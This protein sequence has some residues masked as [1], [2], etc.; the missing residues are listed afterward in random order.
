M[1]VYRRDDLWLERIVFQ[2][3]WTWH[4]V[5]RQRDLTVHVDVYTPT[6]T[7][8][9]ELIRISITASC[10]TDHTDPYGRVRDHAVFFTF[11]PIRPLGLTTDDLD[12][13]LRLL[14]P[15]CHRQTEYAMNLAARTSHLTSICTPQSVLAGIDLRIQA[16]FGTRWSRYDMRSEERARHLWQGTTPPDSQP[17]AGA[18]SSQDPPAQI[19]ASTGAVQPC[20][21]PRG[22]VCI[23]VFIRAHNGVMLQELDVPSFEI[24]SDSLDI[25]PFRSWRIDLNNGLFE[26]AGEPV[27]IILATHPNGWQPNIAHISDVILERMENGAEV[28]DKEVY[29]DYHSL[30]HERLNQFEH[31][32]GG[33]FNVSNYE[34]THH[35]FGCILIGNYM[36]DSLFARHESLALKCVCKQMNDLHVT[37]EIRAREAYHRFR[38][39]TRFTVGPFAKRCARA[40]R[41][42]AGVRRWLHAH[43]SP[44]P[45]IPWISVDRSRLI[46]G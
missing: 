28:I 33:R 44:D 2:A 20:P 4:F 18:G 25:E 24:G 32:T 6:A 27:D 1:A 3:T 8:A 19:A 30:L 42:C 37:W 10:V 22:G 17:S 14:A 43:R 12:G 13:F 5:L 36:E 46:V 31:A 9:V 16:N 34:T 7:A 21:R 26:N 35:L 40:W 15:A 41:V 38:G 29:R 23:E 45:A 39:R 11:Q